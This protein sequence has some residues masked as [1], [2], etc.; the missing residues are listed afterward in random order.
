MAD[1]S[2]TVGPYQLGPTDLRALN[3][4]VRRTIGFWLYCTITPAFVMFGFV[5]AAIFLQRVVIPQWFGFLPFDGRD[6]FFVLPAFALAAIYLLV[7]PRFLG[8]M[9]AHERKRRARDVTLTISPN[10]VSTQSETTQSSVTWADI[11]RIAAK[12]KHIFLFLTRTSAF[13]VPKRVF[14]KP[15][16][17]T[18]F[19]EAARSWYAT[20]I[21]E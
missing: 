3:W 6:D 10:G 5:G 11:E 4:A 8:Q 21:K 15:E 19:L 13:I 16:D 14:A 7:L 2:H 18:A 20:A 1:E 9:S 12:R 17:A